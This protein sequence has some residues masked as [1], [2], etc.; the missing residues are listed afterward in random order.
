MAMSLKGHVI[1]LSVQW[2]LLVEKEAID[3]LCRLTTSVQDYFLCSSWAKPP[4]GNHAS[5]EQQAILTICLAS[6]VDCIVS[7]LQFD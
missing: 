1:P 4:R 6:S 7:N 2:E 5:V 3:F